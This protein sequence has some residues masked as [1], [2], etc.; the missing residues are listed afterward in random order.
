MGEGME[1]KVIWSEKAQADLFNI[2]TYLSKN[3]DAARKLGSNLIR[4][5]ERLNSTSHVWPIFRLA[6]SPFIHSFRYRNYRVIYEINEARQTVEVLR[7]RH[8][9]QRP[10]TPSELR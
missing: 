8:G 2:C 1:Y 4:H 7:I 9:A 10:I 3:P 6:K 5:I